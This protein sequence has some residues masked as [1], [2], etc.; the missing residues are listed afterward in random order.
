[1]VFNNLERV[2]YNYT[3]LLGSGVG[4]STPFIV[5]ASKNLSNINLF[6]HQLSIPDYHKVMFNNQNSSS[7][8]IAGYGQSCEET[9]TRTL[10]ETIERYSFMS[11]YYLLKDEIISDTYENLKK[12]NLILSLD[13]INV[14]SPNDKYFKKIEEN[15]KTDWIL[16]HNYLTQEDMYIPFCMVGAK[17]NSC[18]PI[19]SMST[20]TATHITEKK[21]LINA[22][23]EAYQLDAFMHAWYGNKK[24]KQINLNNKFSPSFNS[25]INKTFKNRDDIKIIVL[26]NNFKNTKFKNF[27]TIIKSKE[28]KYPYC[29]VGI[30]GGLNYEYAILRS[31]MEATAIYV[32]LQ[33]FYLYEFDN[34]NKINLEYA[35]NS[36]N[37]DDSFI[38]WS[39][40]ND[41]SLKEK[42]LNSIISEEIIEFKNSDNLS[43]DDELEELL[44]IAR[45]KLSYL[46]ILDITPSEIKKYG[47]STIRIIAP[48]LLPMCFPVLPYINHPNFPQGVDNEFFPHP[49]P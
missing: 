28:G 12:N 22:L 7:Y 11:S 20:G 9:L 40:F 19:P 13:L 10:G 39:N 34:V 3:Q 47:Y 37:L 49:L 2:K 48:E 38:F 4:L 29:S 26:E 15:T 45:D 8:H 35:S 41:L 21:A 24:L 5:S 36:Y 18:T 33:G 31:I 17:R 6:I 32:N 46:F 16:L 30:Q 1:M 42:K 14:V 27:I 23:S 43:E 44:K 25:I